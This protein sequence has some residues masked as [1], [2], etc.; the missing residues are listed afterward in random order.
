MHV[1]REVGGTGGENAKSEV[2]LAHVKAKAD[3]NTK[4][5]IHPSR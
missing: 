4:F 3:K 1:E 2:R 5:E